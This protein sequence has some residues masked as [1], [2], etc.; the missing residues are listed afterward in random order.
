[1][2]LHEKERFKIGNVEQM[3]QS[4]SVRNFTYYSS[5]S[6]EELGHVYGYELG[7]VDYEQTGHC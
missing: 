1:M 6:W 5:K 4:S 3:S 7:D 2:G